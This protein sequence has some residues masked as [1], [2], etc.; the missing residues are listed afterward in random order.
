MLQTTQQS[1]FMTSFREPPSLKG[2]SSGHGWSSTSTSSLT[3][4]TFSSVSFTS[5]NNRTLDA[6]LVVVGIS[7]STRSI[8]SVTVTG[9]GGSPS[10]TVNTIITHGT[11]QAPC[12]IYTVEGLRTGTYDVTVVFSGGCVGAGIAGH[13]IANMP[14]TTTSVVVDNSGADP[15]GVDSTDGGHKAVVAL[16]WNRSTTTSG[17]DWNYSGVTYSNAGTDEGDFSVG[18]RKF[19]LFGS[20]YA[21]FDSAG[22]NNVQVDWLG[23]VLDPVLLWAE[24]NLPA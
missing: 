13:S 16:A 22:S 9:S 8:S 12:G 24:F 1:G 15:A 17:H 18:S 7:S 2:P 4:Y 19:S 6:S 20:S 14:M 11:S 21:D 3:T 5:E 10:Y 23:G